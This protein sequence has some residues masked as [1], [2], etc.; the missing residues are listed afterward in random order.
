[1]TSSDDE[2][3]VVD[4]EYQN[5]HLIKAMN[6]FWRPPVEELSTS[7][8]QSYT[9]TS[10]SSPGNSSSDNDSYG[11]TGDHPMSEQHQTKSEECKFSTNVISGIINNQIIQQKMSVDLHFARYNQQLKNCFQP[12]FP[13]MTCSVCQKG[14]NNLQDLEI[15]IRSS[16]VLNGLPYG[17]PLYRKP[18]NADMML[19]SQKTHILPPRKEKVYECHI[20][21]KQFKRSSTL[22]TH[23]LIHSDTRPFPC[24]YCGKRFHQKSDMKK[25][26]YVHTGEKPHSCRICGKSFSQSSNLITHMR[27][28]QG[29]KPFA[30][31]ECGETFQRKIDMR[32]HEDTVHLKQ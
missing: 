3:I 11:S 12:S 7:S 32:K 26:T 9:S 1:M 21:Q 18:M 28:H 2:V 5:S 25:H 10:P 4:N 31:S 23:L 15:H 30:C 20:C 6:G 13:T 22:S 19:A 16:H 17:Y 29:V 8:S 14:F 24:P 27:K